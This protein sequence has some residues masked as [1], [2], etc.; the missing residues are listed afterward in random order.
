MAADVLVSVAS[1]AGVGLGGGLSYLAQITSLR[2][3]GRTEQWR[4]TAQT[5]EARRAERL[6]ELRRFIQV[7]QQGERTAEERRATPTPEWLADAR[8]VMDELW[9]RERM[10][11]VLFG[12]SLHER[13]RAYVVAINDILWEEQADEPIWDHLQGPKVAFLDAARAELA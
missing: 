8:D 4:A 10:I 11:H 7:T 12:A 2:H 13:A 1:L 9:V 5:A 3:A 6:E